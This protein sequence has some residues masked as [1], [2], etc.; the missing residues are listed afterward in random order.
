MTK[1]KMERDWIFED[2]NQSIKP[3]CIQ[4]EW[5]NPDQVHNQV[6]YTRGKIWS[7]V[8]IWNVTTVTAINMSNKN[9]TPSPNR[10]HTFSCKQSQNIFTASINTP[11]ERSAIRRSD[12][13]V[14][15]HWTAL[16]AGFVSITTASE[17]A[18]FT[19]AVHQLVI[20][21]SGA[22]RKF[23]ASKCQH[24]IRTFDW[25]ANSPW[26]DLSPLQRSPQNINTQS[27]FTHR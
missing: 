10:D 14:C 19:T 6:N 16:Q 24:V 18:V 23:R 11:M 13:A 7:L 20:L 1:T 27:W 8:N 17:S 15:S 21:R 26:D 25:D 2:G 12:P 9:M 5:L 3:T 22:A 4:H